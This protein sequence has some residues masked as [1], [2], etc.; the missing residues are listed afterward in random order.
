M[1][2]Y[3][4][5]YYMYYDLFHIQGFCYLSWISGMWNKL[6]L[7]LQLHSI[8][9]SMFKCILYHSSQHVQEP[10]W[11]CPE[12][13]RLHGICVAEQQFC[14]QLCAAVLIKLLVTSACHTPHNCDCPNI[15]F[16]SV[17]NNHRLHTDI[18][19]HAEAHRRSTTLSIACT[20]LT[21]FLSFYS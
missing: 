17:Q 18:N 20:T 14:L 21:T 1:L 4:C 11:S 6:Q 10:I 16:H 12:G 2:Y 15:T 7:Q 8:M 19:R 9:A 13:T 3:V 5:S